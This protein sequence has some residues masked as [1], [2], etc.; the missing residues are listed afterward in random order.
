MHGINFAIKESIRI[1]CARLHETNHKQKIDRNIF[2]K[3]LTFDNHLTAFVN[4]SQLVW[5]SVRVGKKSLNA[6]TRSRWGS[7]SP[8]SARKGRYQKNGTRFVVECLEENILNIFSGTFSVENIWWI[9]LL[10]D[11]RWSSFVTDAPS[12]KL[13][14]SAFMN[15]SRLR[16]SIWATS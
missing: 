14:K 13:I 16:M 2:L 4:K 8:K 3:S 9:H 7:L 5:E 6:I 11:P 15:I 1:N 12:K 10:A